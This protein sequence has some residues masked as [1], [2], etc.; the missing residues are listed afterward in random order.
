MRRK[1]DLPVRTCVV[2]ERPCDWRKTA[3]LPANRGHS[4]PAGRREIERPGMP[5]S[6]R[7]QIRQRLAAAESL[8]LCH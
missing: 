4:Y 2:C 7:P 3:C 5:D 1:R 6:G 8:V